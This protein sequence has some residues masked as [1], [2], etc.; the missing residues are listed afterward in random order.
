MSSLDI[1][2]LYVESVFQNELAARFHI[3]AH[4]R[5]EDLIGFQQ[6]LRLRGLLSLSWP[7]RRTVI[8][9]LAL[10]K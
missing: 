3:L 4:Q 7:Q 9:N 5:R 2:V 10:R 6:V 1:Q 8:F